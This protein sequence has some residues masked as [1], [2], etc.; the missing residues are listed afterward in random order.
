[1]KAL[2]ATAW[3]LAA[4]V[5]VG[6]WVYFYLSSR[7]VDLGAHTRALAALRSLA[8]IDHR[9]D[10]VARTVQAGET[11][12][13]VDF[14]AGQREAAQ[15]LARG[16]GASDPATGQTVAALRRA[17]DEKAALGPKLV[18]AGTSY[19]SALKEFEAARAALG[20]ALAEE[21]PAPK[22][23]TP[24][25]LP[26]ADQALRIE[27]LALR[28]AATPGSDAAR[29]L[30][31]AAGEFAG[32]GAPEP[33][34]G[35]VARFADASR[36]LAAAG[37]QRG[38][39]LDEFANV[40]TGPRLDTL[41]RVLERDYGDAIADAERYRIYLLFY[42][43]FLLVVIGYYAWK[44]AESLR[45][46]RRINVELQ[47]ANETLEQRVEER[48]REL[49]D[50]MQRLKQSEAMLIQSEKMSSL[51]QM[52]AGV[53]HEVNTP[54]AYVK[55]SLDAVDTRLPEIADLAAETEHLLGMLE[56]ADADEDTLAAQFAKVTGLVSGMKSHDA[57]GELRALVGDGR[58]GIQ[59]ISEIVTSLRDFS[60]LDRSKIAEFD[61]N[62]G[63]ESTLV[64]GRN[65]LKGRQV[66]KELGR[67]PRIE[68]MPSQL[69]QVFLNLVTNA[70]QA[71]AERNGE[72]VV[73]TRVEDPAH[74]A[75]DVIDNGHGIPPEI[76]KKIFDPF[77][78]TK[79]VGK[80][81]GLGLSICY[82]IV[83]SH[84]GRIDVES[85]VGNGTRFTVILPVKSKLEAAAA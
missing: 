75:V 12:P 70:A 17:F 16:L 42:S 53:A 54:L 79:D 51:G 2:R 85:Q 64:I 8:E 33:L 57:L 5:L 32:A 63:I 19:L 82:K 10:G 50:A 1:M 74:V 25:Y 73:R 20:A 78:T 47:Q 15:I 45:T 46:I 38:Q 71:T 49:S 65:V 81:T 31:V 77:F 69:N 4:A 34:A 18:A 83:E 84:G 13:A 9:W 28:F 44:L 6:G 26:F 21:P 80:G 55:S 58:H 36:A 52:V 24:P 11:P 7:A 29:A 72:I 37:L 59:R 35:P 48:T 61:V 43:G 68:C 40:S 22:G 56:G 41:S 39:V 3:V 60:R 30:T 14:A 23:G 27:A 62:E 66:K 67:L 76:R